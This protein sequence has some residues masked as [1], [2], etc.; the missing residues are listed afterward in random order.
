LRP[1]HPL[2]AVLHQ[3]SA[4]ILCRASCA[5]SIKHYDKT[6]RRCDRTRTLV[7]RLSTRPHPFSRCS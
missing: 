6:V 3:Y 4:L 2:T 5:G 1:I 7:C